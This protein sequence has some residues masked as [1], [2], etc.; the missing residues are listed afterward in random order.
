MLAHRPHTAWF[1]TWGAS[2]QTLLKQLGNMLKETDRNKG[3]N[4][5]TLKNVSTSTTIE[6]VDK[7]PTLQDL[8]VDIKLFLRQVVV[9]KSSTL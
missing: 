3:G 6:P 2:S 5:E 9:S 8:G 7:L 1:Y 4:L